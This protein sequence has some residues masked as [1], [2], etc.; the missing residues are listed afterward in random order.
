MAKNYLRKIVVD[1]ETYLWC[2]MHRHIKHYDLS[3]CAE[4]LTI[5]PYPSKRNYVS[6]RFK[7]EE[8]KQRAGKK[9]V[10]NIGY[11]ESGILWLYDQDG[12]FHTD[13]MF[14]PRE[15]AAEFNLN[16]PKVVAAII[17]LLRTTQWNLA[18]AKGALIIE[19]GLNWL[20]ENY[21]IL[22]RG[23]DSPAL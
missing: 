22:Q 4:T 15:V 2:R 23:I 8:H 14:R 16:R 7:D 11:P 6:I 18:D 3:P 20:D 1:G 17:R 5:L 12:P 10:W 21:K 13:L 19:N 9:G